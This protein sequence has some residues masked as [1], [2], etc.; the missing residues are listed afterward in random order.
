MSIILVI[1]WDNENNFR[2]SKIYPIN[3]L[4][5]ISTGLVFRAERM[6]EQLYILIHAFH[7]NENLS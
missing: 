4:R 5:G 3:K 7:M 1:L 6:E 2:Y